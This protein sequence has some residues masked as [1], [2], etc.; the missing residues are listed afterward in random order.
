MFATRMTSPESTPAVA[1]RWPLIPASFFAMT[2][3]LAET[4]SAWRLAAARWSLPSWVGEAME[5]GALLSF[6]A[7]GVLFIHKWI[8]RRASA[9]EEFRDPVQSSF[10]ALIPE[11]VILLA[12]AALPH[13]HDVAVALF[14]LGSAANVLYGA[15]RLSS[16]WRENREA[17][18]NQPPMFLTFTASV[19]VN[20][21]AAGLLGYEIYG[22]ALLGI[23]GL[24]WL[25][26]DSVIAHQL[27]TG[28]LPTRSRNF[29]G[30]YMAPP[31]VALVAY[32]VL[33]G[34]GAALPVVAALG[35]YAL[36]LSGALLMAW[37]WLAAQAFAP[38][39]WAYTFG[40]AT[41]AQGLILMAG[42]V[43]SPAL[44][45]LAA[46]VF[47]ASL[48][49]TAGV[50]LGTLLLLRQ[51]RYFPAPMPAATISAT[52]ASVKPPPAVSKT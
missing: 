31:V 30:I 28:Q 7:W 1:S 2:L 18:H 24:S 5:L 15:W 43:A 51:G 23:G 41:L 12:L 32:Q 33:A 52:L 25:I 42:R 4:G 39:Y 20:A 34:D 44:T 38:G 16:Q 21:L 47:A 9:M 22:W 26:V 19:L 8:W 37:R 49:L 11:S 46:L 13:Q 36:F 27:F 17:A 40:L 48:A 3:G 6:L 45:L 35:G 10:L 29:M 50:A 14:W